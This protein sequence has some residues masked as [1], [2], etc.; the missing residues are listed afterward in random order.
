VVRRERKHFLCKTAKNGARVKELKGCFGVVARG[1]NKNQASLREGKKKAC[2]ANQMR[3]KNENGKKIMEK[4]VR[5]VKQ[6]GG[7]VCNLQKLLILGETADKQRIEKQPTD[8]QILSKITVKKAEGTRT[9][10]GLG[11]SVRR[12]ESRQWWP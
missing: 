10:E 7:V 8:R 4:M 1:R 9:T 6:K 5:S 11:K 12:K 3:D 2:R